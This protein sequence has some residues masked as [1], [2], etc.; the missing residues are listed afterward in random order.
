MLF[1]ANFQYP[2]TF[3]LLHLVHWT[4]CKTSLVDHTGLNMAFAAPA[5]EREHDQD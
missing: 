1:R 4:G 2:G 3:D 5:E